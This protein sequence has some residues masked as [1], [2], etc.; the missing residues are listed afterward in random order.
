MSSLIDYLF[1]VEKVRE[2]RKCFECECLDVVT[3]IMK[4]KDEI[5]SGELSAFDIVEKTDCSFSVKFV[6]ELLELIK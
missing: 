5:A 1:E 6:R 2:Y 3:F 4:N